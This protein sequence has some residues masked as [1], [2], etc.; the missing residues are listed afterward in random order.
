M[1]SATWSFSHV[2]LFATPWTVAH[3]APLSMGFT[4]QEHWSGL[5]A[6]LQG[7]FPTQGSNLS[8][9]CLLHRQVG[10]LPR[11]PPGLQTRTESPVSSRL[12]TIDLRVISKQESNPESGKAPPPH[13]VPSR[14]SGQAAVPPGTGCPCPWAAGT[15]V[16]A[17][18]H[19]GTCRR[20][21]HWPAG[22]ARSSGRPS[23]SG[24]ESTESAAL[25][26][27]P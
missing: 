20:V 4:K 6:L 16:T 17:A 15:R 27:T 13:P 24:S 5:H 14:R 7:I 26:P 11:A 21:R 1:K 19:P 25:Q 9:L 18:P 2:R 22:T 10:S 23:G 12:Q 8:L 3:Q